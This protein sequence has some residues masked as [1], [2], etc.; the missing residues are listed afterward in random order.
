[1]KKLL[2]ILLTVSLALTLAACGLKVGDLNLPAA[3]SE[4]VLEKGEAKT[5]DLINEFAT[6][7]YATEE[8]TAE[9]IAEVLSK[10][11]ITWASS[12]ITVAVV[13]DGTITAVGAGSASVTAS[14]DEYSLTIPVKVI[15]TPTDMTVSES[16]KLYING[17]NTAKLEINFTP[18]DATE[19]TAAFASSDGS[20]ATVS[21]DGTVTAVGAGGCEV[22]VSCG[23]LTKTVKVETAVKATELNLKYKSGS[24]YVGGSLTLK[25]Y[26]LPENAEAE[27][28]SFASSNTGVA[29]VNEKGTVYGAGAGV[30][31]ITV[32][33][34]N[35]L[36]AQYKITVSE[37]PVV[38]TPS[39]QA[40]DGTPS[41]GG[42]S[43][44]EPY[45][46]WVPIGE[47]GSDGGY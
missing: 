5:V 24:L 22:T 27:T 41:G 26:L 28:L 4:I 11:S 42:N 29:T 37:K 8:I 45:E 9:E 43:A 2:A 47:G 35:G 6:D 17:G 31:T 23:G 1:M 16:V 15:V 20:I 33:S 18:T 7:K 36:T 46:D 32:T 25:P 14:V 34:A 38:S 21:A 13:K 44:N 12:D 19:T 39:S 3:L 10:L 30:A 40:T